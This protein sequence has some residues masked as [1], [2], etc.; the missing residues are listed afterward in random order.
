MEGINGR[1]YALF[2]IASRS[3]PSIRV[4]QP[5]S[6]DVKWLLARLLLAF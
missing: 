5:G 3:V 1:D 4:C 6:S 2:L